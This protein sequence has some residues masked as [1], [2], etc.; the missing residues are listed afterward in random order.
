MAEQ[1]RQLALVTGASSGIGFELARQFAE[2]GFDL[3]IAAEG[4]D[5]DQAARE[6]EAAGA[7][8]TPCQVDLATY[9]GVEELWRM[10]ESRGPLDAAAIN[11]GVGISGTFLDS[12]LEE[13]L[14]LISLNVTGAVHLSRRILPPMVAAG[15]GRLMFT[16]SIAG[17][18]PGPYQSTYNASKSFL[19]FFAQALRTEL[20]ESGITVTALMPGAT[21]TEFFE[22]AGLEDT[23]LAQSK[24]DEPADVAEEAFEAMMEGKD[25]IIT[26]SIKNKAMVAGAKIMPDTV[27]AKVHEMVAKPESERD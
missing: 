7:D 25:H 20:K 6:L 19:Y 13:H 4:D 23:K 15:S 9:D 27:A 16:S 18:M 14:N 11:A 24:K 1:Q 26:G 5:I 17:T 10:I 8:V 22:R 3:I 2:H 21:D 12:P